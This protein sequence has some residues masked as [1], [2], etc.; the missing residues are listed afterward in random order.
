MLVSTH[1]TLINNKDRERGGG[2]KHNATVYPFSCT[3]QLVSGAAL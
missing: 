1:A 2:E 3:C